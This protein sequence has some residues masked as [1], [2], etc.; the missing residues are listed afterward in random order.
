MGTYVY[1]WKGDEDISDTNF[2]HGLFYLHDGSQSHAFEHCSTIAEEPCHKAKADL[3]RSLLEAGLRFF[4]DFAS[5]PDANGVALG[6]EP[7]VAFIDEDAD[8]RIGVDLATGFARSSDLDATAVGSLLALDGR[9]YL[10]SR[11]LLTARI[12]GGVYHMDA[13]ADTAFDVLLLDLRAEDDLSS[14]FFGFRG[15]L[16][17]GIEQSIT[18]AV[19][20]G[21]IGRLD[22]WSNFPTIDWTDTPI[23]GVIGHDNRIADEDFLS[24]SI[25]ARVTVMFG[26]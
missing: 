5:G 13:D 24:L 19:G 2:G 7:F 25:G 14:D 15:Q 10:G 9:H 21:V 22:Y 4:H 26:G 12:A 18:D 6:I 1:G 20:I 16:A 8:S 11:T 23:G 17:F 3:D